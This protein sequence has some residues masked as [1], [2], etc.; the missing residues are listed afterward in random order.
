[1]ST[2]RTEQSACADTHK[3]RNSRLIAKAA[4]RVVLALCATAVANAQ[5]SPLYEINIEPKRIDA[6]LKDFA[7]QT[8]LQVLVLSE[9]AG[10]KV[11][12]KVE[13]KFTEIE[14]LSRLLRDTG[15]VYERIDERTIAVRPMT[16]APRLE[17]T[18]YLSTSDDVIASS[19]QVKEERQQSDSAS[20]TA[21][22]SEAVRLE[23]V[24]VT[25]TNIRGAQPLA[26]PVIRVDQRQI[27]EAG[28]QDLGEVVRSLPLNFSGGQ[29]PGVWVGLSL[30]GGSN[31]NVTSGSSLNLRGLGPD[32]SLTL[33]NGRRLSYDGFGQAINI[34]GIPVAAVD[35]VEIV[36]DGASAI[37]GSDAVAGVA[38]VILKRDYDGVSTTARIG[39]ATEGGGDQIAYGV[40]GGDTWDSGGFI[41]A[42]DFTRSDAIYSR[43]RDYLAHMADSN[44]IFPETK[45][46][47][48]LLSG[49]QLLSPGLSLSIDALYNQTPA[50]QSLDDGAGFR[51]AFWME[52][53]RYVLS[54]TITLD[55]STGWSAALNATYGRGRN[56]AD[57][58]S[59]STTDDTLLFSSR[60]SYQNLTESVEANVE[61]PISGILNGAA[62]A[63]LGVGYRHISHVAG[64]QGQ[65]SRG[66]DQHSSYAFGEVYLPFIS[67]ERRV[68]LVTSL[69]LNGALRHEDYR[70]IGSVTT[71]KL[72]LVYEPTADVALSASWGRSFKAPQLIQQH[73]PVTGFTTLAS[74]L[75]GTGYADS[76]MVLYI[77]GGQPLRPERARSWSTTV[78]F[79]PRE[80]AGLELDLSYFRVKYTDRVAT[81]ITNFVNALSDP[82]YAQFVTLNPSNDLLE[83]LIALDRDGIETPFGPYDPAS[84]VAA[85][86]DRYTNMT[87]QRIDGFDFSARYTFELL[88]DDLILQANASWL[89]S[90]QKSTPAA[91][92]HA[93]AGTIFNPP[94]LRARVG[95]AWRR[96][97]LTF[98]GFVNY[99]D[100]ID[101]TLHMPSERVNSMT[102]LDLTALYA[103][104]STEGWLKGVSSSLSVQNVTNEQPPYARIAPGLHTY[105][106]TNYSAIGRF[107]TLSVTKSW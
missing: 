106:P 55:L 63:V 23:E 66:G 34:A 71:P 56:D 68:P 69:S 14:A 41:A 51:T 89:D 32:A 64:T 10:G 102:T 52:T 90:R 91:P 49:Y 18:S 80:L 92:P 47:D 5:S 74:F 27:R 59:F 40:V 82:L 60:G 48:V 78:K 99:T 1:M 105:D 70:Q 42:Y 9:H 13:G 30:G 21:I 96:Q 3:H 79:H 107:V 73:Q 37:Y 35:R 16:A 83:S 103:A 97:V 67:S 8:G 20:N 12:P 104:P 6:A 72:S 2:R 39:S 58:R 50:H 85:I 87:T 93:L 100:G 54:P 53:E 46:H 28:H 17:K 57:N 45:S 25:G 98:S 31:Q 95:A 24:L 75:G 26:S 4:V 62:R 77:G 11:A 43:Q 29:N 7:K 38:N 19:A 22:E 94:E 65:Q 44:T 81:P 88:G 86:D 84:I 36:A 33:L 76:A 15:L 61:G 101:N